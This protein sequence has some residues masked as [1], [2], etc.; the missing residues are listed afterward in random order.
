MSFGRWLSV[1]VQNLLLR[2]RQPVLADA[3]KQAELLAADLSATRR[4]LSEAGKASSFGNGTVLGC[5][6]QHGEAVSSVH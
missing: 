6:P 4:P 2:F 1:A 5:I 3:Q